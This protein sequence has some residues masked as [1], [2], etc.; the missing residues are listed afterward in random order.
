M[1]MVSDTGDADIGEDEKYPGSD[2]LVVS[3]R[4][5]SGRFVD[6]LR[7]DWRTVYPGVLIRSLPEFERLGARGVKTSS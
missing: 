1:G 4:E 6:R 2:V 3:G 7:R 5:I